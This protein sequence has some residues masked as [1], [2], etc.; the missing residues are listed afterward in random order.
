MT[1]VNIP[2]KSRVSAPVDASRATAEATAHNVVKWA[3]EQAEAEGK[4]GQKLMGF[5]ADIVGLPSVEAHTIFRAT[6]DEE[7]RVLREGMK[8]GGEVPANVTL[9]YSEES[10]KV[11]VSCLRTISVAASLGWKPEAD[12]TWALAY[13]AAVA[14]KQTKADSGVV[15][16]MAGAKRGRKAK[17][18][19]ASP[20]APE[21][22][23]VPA[24]SLYIQAVNITGKLT[25]DELR[26]LQKHIGE[27]LVLRNIAKK[28]Q[29]FEKAKAKKAA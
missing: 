22:A 8:A 10:F 1:V 7:L 27:L 4:K 28:G 3:T 18:A 9:G 5:V 20:K 29:A 21:G 19:A 15:V 25:D 12:A 13:K 17:P 24:Q 11:I 6:L 23:I 14:Y 26:H 2:K 16:G